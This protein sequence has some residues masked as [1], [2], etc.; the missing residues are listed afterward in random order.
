MKKS[1]LCLVL[2][3][4][5]LSL[6]VAAQAPEPFTTSKYLESRV[7][8]GDYDAIAEAGKSGDLTLI[9]YLK[10]LSSNVIARTKSNTPEFQAHIALV[11]LGDNGAL[12]QILTEV[13]SE[14]FA[15]QDNAI[16]K[17][18]LIGGKAAFKKFYELLEDLAPR[19]SQS[20]VIYFPRGVVVMLELSRLVSDPPTMPSKYDLKQ[21]AQSW[22][23]WFNRNKHLIE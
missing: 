5:P 18:S 21:N 6:N 2:L 7:K 12:Q 16:K 23:E 14:N 20:D 22:K 1:L 8:T 13:D 4:T 17:L 10:Q 19:E 3:A 11:K 15:I 9:P